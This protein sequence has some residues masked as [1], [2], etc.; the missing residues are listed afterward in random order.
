M[1]VLL[2]TIYDR[3]NLKKRHVL[4]KETFYDRVN[5]KK[6]Y[7]LGKEILNII[8]TTSIFMQSLILRKRCK[9]YYIFYTLTVFVILRNK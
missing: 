9:N 4:E 1:I 5:L 3:V 6:K 2:E 8:L 7:I